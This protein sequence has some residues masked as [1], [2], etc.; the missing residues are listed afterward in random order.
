MA[1]LLGMI[2]SGLIVGAGFAVSGLIV[3]KADQ[4]IESK[5]NEH[6][7]KPETTFN[8]TRLMTDKDKKD[9]VD[10]LLNYLLK[11]DKVSSTK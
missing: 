3:H 11:N 6:N 8:D 2:A 7:E 1:T 5:I 9:N 10:D 4:L